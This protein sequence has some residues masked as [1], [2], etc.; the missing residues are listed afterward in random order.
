MSSTNSRL[1]I[2]PVSLKIRSLA[3][4]IWNADRAEDDLP[5]LHRLAIIYLMVPIVL[6]LVG[7]FR[8][9][10]G[11]PAAILIIL[12]LR[13]ALSGSIRL[14]PPRPMI[15]AVVLFAALW[16]TSSAAGGVFDATNH[17][18]NKHRWIL[19]NLGYYSWPTIIPDATRIWIS[20]HLTLPKILN[21][22]S[23]SATTSAGTWFQVLLR[24]LL[25]RTR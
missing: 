23:C 15:L 21:G 10:F 11:I 4:R 17:D 25:G 12:A 24:A 14:T 13:P 5:L 2:E 16:V 18:W 7:W 8:W 9:W 3:T 19:L 1:P 20:L 6:W 22:P